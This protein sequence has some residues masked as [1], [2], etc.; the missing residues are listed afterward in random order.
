M[1]Q[2][3]RKIKKNQAKEIKPKSKVNK[4]KTKQKLVIK[5]NSP[6]WTPNGC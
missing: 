6:V 4:E 3:V 2:I 5:K 1:I